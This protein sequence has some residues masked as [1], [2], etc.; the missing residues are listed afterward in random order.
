[1]LPA[2]IAG[3]VREM[4]GGAGGGGATHNWHIHAVDGESVRRLFL[5]HQ[6]ALADAMARAVRNGR[7]LKA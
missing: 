3:A 4:A 1:M 5:N 6:Q 2:S 7:F